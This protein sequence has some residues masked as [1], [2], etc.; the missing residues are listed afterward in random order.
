MFDFRWEQAHAPLRRSGAGLSATSLARAD[1]PPN[2]NAAP[3]SMIPALRAGV[4]GLDAAMLRWWLVPSWSEGPT[5]RYAMFNAR[6]E[7]AASS[8]AFGGPYRRSRCVTPV[9]GYYEWVADE[10]GAKRP[11]FFRRADG[12]VL[13][14]AALWDRWEGGGEAIES[15]AILTRAATGEMTAHHSRVPCVLEPERVAAWCD[16]EMTDPDQI[17]GFLG[18]VAD[19]VLSCHAVSRRVNSAKNNDPSLIE[20]QNGA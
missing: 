2:Y 10:A 7:T 6:A 14:L 3:E 11:Y 16:P 13:F 8:R 1:P 12:E 18:P 15:C 17:G 9:S 19:G 4:G 20:P 5:R